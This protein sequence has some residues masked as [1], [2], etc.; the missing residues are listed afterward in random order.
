MPT[1][2]KSKTKLI[3]ARIDKELVDEVNQVL[4]EIGIGV[5]DAIKAFF[6]KVVK[7]RA[8]PFGLTA[9]KTNSSYFTPEQEKEVE[10]ALDD[11]ENGRVYSFETE[12]ELD[13]FVENI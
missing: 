9:S 13:K 1:A 12:E 3:Q 6:K 2:T 5:S 7:E 11:I 4:D 10:M 8:I